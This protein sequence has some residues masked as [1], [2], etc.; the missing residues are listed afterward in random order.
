MQIYRFP[1][2]FR[3]SPNEAESAN[4]LDIQVNI[5]LTWRKE[6][7][8][9]KK[10]EPA[11]HSSLISLTARC[12]KSPASS[13]AASYSIGIFY[14]TQIRSARESSAVAR[15]SSMLRAKI[16]LNPTTPASSDLFA[17]TT[18]ARSVPHHTFLFHLLFPTR[19]NRIQQRE[20]IGRGAEAERVRRTER[21]R[22]GGRSAR[23]LTTPARA[24]RSRCCR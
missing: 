14:R 9:K 12:A 8:Q 13:P 6:N 22:C 21:A 11:T 2:F 16:L 3:A 7:E 24:G 10:I 1:P 20:R 4:Y 5:H 18:K 19:L 17:E 15:E 23:E